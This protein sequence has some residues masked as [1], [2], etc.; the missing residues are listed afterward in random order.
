V[1]DHPV[2]SNEEWLQARRELLGTEKEL[3]RLR[4]ELGQKIRDLPW[5]RVEK[6]YVFDGPDGKESLSD[7]FAGRSQLLIYHFMFGPDWDDGCPACSL[8]AD[9]YDPS[10]VHLNHRDVTMITVSRAPLD[11]LQAYKQRMGWG[12]KWVSSGACDFNGDF[13]VSFTPEQLKNDDVFYNYDTQN[14]FKMEDMPG[15]SVF[16]KDADGTIYHTYSSFAR[17]LETF[18]GVYRLLDIA[19]KGRDEAD[20]QFGMAWIRRHDNYGK[21]ELFRI[22]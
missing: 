18:L 12:F 10:I 15:I 19:P 7:L 20:L 8:L 17:G 16:T 9:H 22:E 4:D 5:R 21:D 6:N 2:V 14:S 3:T 11:K 1:P 13:N